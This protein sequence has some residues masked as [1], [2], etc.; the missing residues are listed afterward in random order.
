M[1]KSFLLLLSLPI[2]P[3][4]FV[5]VPQTKLPAVYSQTHLKLSFDS[6]N[7][8]DLLASQPAPS[9]LIADGIMDSIGGPLITVLEVILIIGSLLFGLT[10]LSASFL[11][12]KAAEQLEEQCK[13]LDP[14]LWAEYEA[15]LQ[16]G[17]VM[18]MR[19]D[20]LQELG[21]KVTDLMGK[22]MDEDFIKAQQAT[23]SPG[24]DIVDAEVLE[25]S[26]DEKKQDQ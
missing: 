13:Q 6:A 4:A 19:P 18:A 20:L 16:P 14:A 26:K 21:N 9:L 12:P 2:L 8:G 7:F 11:I 24:S 15:K 1:M 5:V 10:Y 22:Q 25:V 17:E 3:S 23:T